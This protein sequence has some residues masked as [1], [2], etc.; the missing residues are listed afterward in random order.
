[1]CK[2][3]TL[4]VRKSVR[5]AQ[6]DGQ[7]SPGC[8][9]FVNMASSGWFWWVCSSK[10]GGFHC[11]TVMIR[12]RRV[13]YGQQSEYGQSWGQGQCQDNGQFSFW[14]TVCKTVHPMLSD[15]CSVLSVTFV[16]CGQMV[17]WI[18]MK[19]GMQVYL[20]PGHTVLDGDPARS[21]PKGHRPPNCR[22][23]SVVAK[24]LH[25]SRCH[26]VWR[27]MQP[28]GHN[29]YWPTIRGPMPLWRRTSWVPI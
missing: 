20:G 14:A 7:Y 25:G 3:K 22:P 26:L 27:S 11:F 4:D 18:K 16:H 8:S 1:M 29:R 19:L 10:K 6:A 28:F 9:L 12:V 21:P 24:G 23:I 5:L 17:G 2:Q 15:G 13:Q